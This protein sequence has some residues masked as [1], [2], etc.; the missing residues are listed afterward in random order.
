MAKWVG[1]QR[2]LNVKIAVVGQSGSGKINI[3]NQLA[4]LT[5]MNLPWAQPQKTQL[6]GKQLTLTIP[7]VPLVDHPVAPLQR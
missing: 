1:K 2:D 4:A 3:I 7:Y 6:W 5:W